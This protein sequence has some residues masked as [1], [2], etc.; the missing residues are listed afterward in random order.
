[1]RT[2]PVTL[3]TRRIDTPS[4][5]GEVEKTS[6]RTFFTTT[7]PTTQFTNQLQFNSIDTQTRSSWH[8]I[9]NLPLG[10]GAQPPGNFNFIAFFNLHALDTPV[11]RLDPTQ[12]GVFSERSHHSYNF[13]LLALDASVSKISNNHHYPPARTAV[14]DNAALIDIRGKRWDWIFWKYP[15]SPGRPRTKSIM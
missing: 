10:R 6:I 5:K 1:M 4:K 3:S 14:A 12:G 11:S 8:P 9:T 2:F 13:T 15:P 7:M